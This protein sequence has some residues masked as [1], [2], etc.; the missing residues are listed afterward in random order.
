MFSDLSEKE[1]AFVADLKAE[2]G[3]DLEGWLA[4]VREAR[5]THRDEIIDWLRQRKFTFARASWIERIHNNNGKL[6]YG[7]VLPARAS[8]PPTKAAPHSGSVPRELVTTRQPLQSTPLPSH[9]MSAEDSQRDVDHLL[10]TA[11]AYRPLAQ[12]LIRYILASVPSAR[13]QAVQ[14]RIV[15][16]TAAPFASLLPSPRDVRLMLNCRTPISEAWSTPKTLSTLESA[17][18]LTHMLVLTDAR[19]LD[20]ALKAAICLSAAQCGLT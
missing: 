5:L 20:D 7:D 8:V 13:I 3:H 17:H 10:Q 9:A 14:G 15:G 12:A 6:I 2:T 18:G 19:Q 4:Q 11:K 16:A 1:R